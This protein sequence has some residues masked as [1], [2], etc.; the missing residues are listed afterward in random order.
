MDIQIQSFARGL[1][2]HFQF[3]HETRMADIPILNPAL[4]VQAVGFEHT[5]HGCLG[6]LITP[7]F[8]NLM[9]V[10]CEG[11]TWEDLPV[12]STQTHRFP[13]GSYEFI[14]NHEDEIGRFQSCSLLSPVLE[15]GDQDTAIQVALASLHAVHDAR[16]RDTDSDT[17]AAEIERIWSGEEETEAEDE[18]EGLSLRERLTEAPMS[19]RDLLRGRFLGGDSEET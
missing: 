5:E 14:V 1:E 17:R 18:E 7:W 19:R 15:I 12:G 8:I 6:V 2:K 11:D 3:V 9:L 10:P 4:Q 16:F 13:S